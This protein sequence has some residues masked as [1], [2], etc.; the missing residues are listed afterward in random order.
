MQIHIERS[1]CQSTTFKWKDFYN[2]LL[3]HKNLGDTTGIPH[4]EKVL[5][6]IGNIQISRVL[7]SL[8][9]IDR[10]AQYGGT[11][12]G[13]SKSDGAVHIQPSADNDLVLG[14]AEELDGDTGLDAG[15]LTRD[16]CGGSVEAGNMKG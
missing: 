13:L 2:N 4:N 16:G 9:Q 7:N 11:L 1:R 10:I 3:P 15:L 8:G 12:I 5:I 14:T 6:D